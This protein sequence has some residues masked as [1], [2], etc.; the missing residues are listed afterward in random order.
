MSILEYITETKD[1]GYLAVNGVEF[2]EVDKLPP[3]ITLGSIVKKIR[4]ILPYHYFENLEKVV[5]KHLDEFNDRHI[6]AVYKDGVFYLT[7]KQENFED[8]LDDV[9]HEFA[10]HVETLFKEEIYS[11]GEVGKEFLK[12]RSQLEF[13]LRS[14]GYWTQEYNFKSVDYDPELDNFLY[15]RVGRNMLKMLTSGLFIRPYA[16]IS[17]REYFATGFEAY[18]LGKKE[19]LQK[20]SPTLYKVIDNL[21]TMNTT[22]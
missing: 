2:H 13:E 1:K 7:N 11:N 9:V 10:H 19:E 5:I 16:S 17:L 22:K 18:Y 20:I 8:V 6:T 4:K 12:K 14:E 3:S 21:H 15:K